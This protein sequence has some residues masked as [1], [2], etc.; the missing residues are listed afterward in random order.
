M[1]KL[2]KK[3]MI[4][5]MTMVSLTGSVF[6]AGVSNTV[7]PAAAAQGAE[8]YGKENT[9]SSTATSAFA[10][11][12][13]NTVKG[14]NGFAVGTNNSAEGWNSFVGGEGAKAKGRNSLAFGATA[15]AITDNTFAIGSQARTNGTNTIAIG[16]GAY[17][18]AEGAVAQG[19]STMV[20]I[21]DGVAIG[22]NS[23]AMDPAVATT[24]INS[25][26]SNSDPSNNH[27][28]KF[29][30]HAFAGS[31]PNSI[32]SFGNANFT[33]QLQNV[34][35]GRVSETSTDAINGS[36]LH[37]VAFE[38]Q[39]HTTI[40]SGNNNITVTLESEPNE[41]GGKEYTIGLS[42][43]FINQINNLSGGTSSLRNIIDANQKEAHKGIAGSAALASL[44]PLDFDPD[45][46]LDVMAGYGHYHNA[47][48]VAIGV[49]YR[50]TEDLMIT[51]GST[52]NGDDDTVFNA[53][54]SYKVGAKSTVSR[55]RM[56][57][58]R[59]LADAKRQIAELQADN[60]KIKSILNSVLGLDDTQL[61][62]VNH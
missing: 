4:M 53:G 14:A 49:A 24:A 25:D 29:S 10:A 26:P 41:N 34:A 2:Q 50:P 8:S 27:K 60:E 1:L 56:A 12:F 61:S 30:N 28:I 43:D 33:R 46:K 42:P 6:A 3:S 62:K 52:V 13:K 37:D 45:H 35:A 48:A 54:I 5:L 36:Q 59:D 9:I 40:K 7:D 16:N 58:A 31:T 23:K 47:N 15:E 38:A 19:S 22:S 21:K 55:S 39:K 44:H 20:G 51:V 32:V 18:Q 57:M 17:A 11:G